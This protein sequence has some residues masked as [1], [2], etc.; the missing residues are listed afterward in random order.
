MREKDIPVDVVELKVSEVIDDVF[1]EPNGNRF[2]ILLHMEQSN[3]VQFYEVEKSNKTGVSIASVK[4]LKQIDEKG[5]SK[6]VWSP[7]GR[8]CVLG[9]VKTSGDL[10]FWDVQDLVLLANG[11]H[12]GCTGIEWDPTGRYVASTVTSWKLKNDTGLIL[13]S[14]S[15]QELTKQN[16][17]SLKQFCWRPRPKSLLSAEDQRK[18]KKN[19]K[20]YSKEFDQEDAIESNKASVD[21]KSRR[22][23]QLAEYKQMME[24][25]AEKQLHEVE[26]RVKIYG[27]DPL[28]EEIEEIE[29]II[30][31]IT[32]EIEEVDEIEA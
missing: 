28:A 19:L 18:I 29:E 20:K 8:I 10:M 25:F 13:W 15:G 3:Y 1:W 12:Y 23:D 5:I 16:I 2:A 6:V 22:K 11:E 7:N 32:E 17:N 21:V 24:E 4:M 27:C 30:E 9:G 26:D 14:L 31:V